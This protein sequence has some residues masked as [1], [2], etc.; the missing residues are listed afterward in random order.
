MLN[1]SAKPD[2]SIYAKLLSQDD[3]IEERIR[4]EFSDAELKTGE[5][6]AAWLNCVLSII[7]QWHVPLV[8]FLL[9]R[10]GMQMESAVV[11]VLWY[12]SEV[13][14]LIFFDICCI[15]LLW[16]YF[17]HENPDQAIELHLRILMVVSIVWDCTVIAFVAAASFGLLL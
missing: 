15:H 10:L 8:L 1:A 12:A 3:N 13:F 6:R 17:R 11:G 9:T 2:D 7:I 5:D 14:W 16:A 4:D